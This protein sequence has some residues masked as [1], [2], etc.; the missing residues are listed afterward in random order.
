METSTLITLSFQAGPWDGCVLE[1]L[2]APGWLS[3]DEEDAS[4]RLTT[5]SVHGGQ[6]RAEYTWERPRS[7]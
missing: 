1:S 6:E 7:A 2:I 4:Y 3:V 5:R